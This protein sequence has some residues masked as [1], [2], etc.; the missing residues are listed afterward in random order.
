MTQRAG[1]W[2]IVL[3]TATFIAGL[4]LYTPPAP[5]AASPYTQ[6]TPAND[7]TA[8]A[9]LTVNGNEYVTVHIRHDEAD[10]QF[11]VTRDYPNVTNTIYYE[12]GEAYQRV[13]ADTEQRYR[14]YTKVTGE[15]RVVS[16][17]DSSMTAVIYEP[18]S[19]LPQEGRS[20]PAVPFEPALRYPGY[21]RVD[22]RS[23]YGEGIAVFDPQP[24]WYSVSVGAPSSS[25]RVYRVT[26]ASGKIYV[27]E[28]TRVLH[29]A[30]VQYQVVNTDSWGMAFVKDNWATNDVR[31]IT[32]S[33]EYQPEEVDITRPEWAEETGT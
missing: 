7:Y 8:D 18:N 30:H 23:Y 11:V 5:T 31:V 10:G 12:D 9:T 25:E 13:V 19:L 32:V 28:E 24:G 33:Y 15:E 3:L 22:D 17:D 6:V 20:H 2:A 29:R 26:N 16:R 14:S 4:F 21:E 27:N 1:F